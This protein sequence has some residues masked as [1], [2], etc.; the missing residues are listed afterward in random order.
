MEDPKLD[1]NESLQLLEDLG[2]GGVSLYEVRTYV[3][4]PIQINLVFIFLMF[5][6]F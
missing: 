2:L 4:I 5:C 3:M 6:F 1:E